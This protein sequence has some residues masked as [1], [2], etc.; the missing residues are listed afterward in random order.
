MMAMPLLRLRANRRTGLRRDHRT[1]SPHWLEYVKVF[2]ALV[3]AA[4]AVVGYVTQ[5]AHERR[6]EVF[7]TYQL[8]LQG[9]GTRTLHEDISKLLEHFKE[10]PRDLHLDLYKADPATVVNIKNFIEEHILKTDGNRFNRV[11]AYLRTAYRFASTG[12]CQ[13]YI[14]S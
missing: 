3:L 12:P 11:L 5:H 10:Y 13:W 6:A 9:E 2:G 14:V 7:Q 8:V 1:G 4:V